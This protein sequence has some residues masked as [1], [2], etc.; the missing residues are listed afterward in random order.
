MILLEKNDQEIASMVES[1]EKVSADLQALFDGYVPILNGERYITD[2]QLSKLL[3][4][5]NRTLQE[6]RTNGYISYIF[7]GG[8]IL[9][10]ES[11]IMEMLDK[12]YIEAWR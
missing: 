6:Y 5:C 4:V 12:A 3:H 8:K 2:K 7:W 11:D 1:L 10:R 9:Y